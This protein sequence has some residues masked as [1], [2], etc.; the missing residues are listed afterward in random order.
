MRLESLPSFE[1]EK[2][3]GKVEV[4]PEALQEA[5]AEKPDDRWRHVWKVMDYGGN[6]AGDCPAHFNFIQ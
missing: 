4:H 3:S 6:M 2:S 5:Q 1:D